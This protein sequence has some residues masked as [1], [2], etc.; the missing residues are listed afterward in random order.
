[1][2]SSEASPD[3]PLRPRRPAWRV[4]VLTAAAAFA[5]YAA[6]VG[7]GPAWQ[8]SGMHQYRVLRAEYTNDW[9]LALAHPLLIAMGQPLRLLGD[10]NLPTAL[11]LLSGLGMALAVANVYLLGRRL[12]GRDAPALIAAGMLAISHTAWWLATIA[13]TYCWVTAGLTAELLLLHA[14]LTRPRW[15]HAA[16]LA[17]ISGLGFSLHNFALLPLPVYVTV[18]VVLLIRRR[19][20]GAVVP[21]VLAAWLAGASL[22]VGLILH[23]GA[24]G[25]DW[26]ATLRSA[27]FGAMWQDHVL[28]SSAAVL[29]NGVLYIAL[30]WPLLAL[31]PVVY[32][33][34]LMPRRAGRPVAAA[35]GAVGLI[36]LLFAI[37][38]PVPDQFMFLLPGYA[39]FAVGAAVGVDGMLRLHPRWRR[40]WTIGLAASIILTPVLYGVA[41]MVLTARG[42]SIRP[43]KSWPYRDENRYWISPWKCGE[44]SGARFAREA[45]DRAAADSVILPSG[46]AT[47]PLQVLQEA[48]GLRKDVWVVPLDHEGWLASKKDLD[49]CRDLAGGRVAYTVDAEPFP[50]KALDETV[51]RRPVGPLVRL[52]WPERAD[53]VASEP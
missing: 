20:P 31:A 24:T 33:W 21:A 32:G 37:R 8:D 7:R 10:A 43:G 15:T 42:K 23:D 47:F 11:S 26:G 40:A 44:T 1:M 5:L 19:L 17:L 6:T 50:L 16:G 28:N 22:Q 9:G 48:E 36:H 38:Y 45:L 46:M 3:P 4:Y 25:G 53:D 2:T 29:R 51:G 18:V 27:L 13:E 39:L 35:L 49:A 52:D 30:S 41:P 12:T 34:A 14:L